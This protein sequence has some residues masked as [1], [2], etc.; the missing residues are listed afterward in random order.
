ME[1]LKSF[2][3][4]DAVFIRIRMGNLDHQHF[5]VGQKNGMGQKLVWVEILA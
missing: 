1:L 3:L 5:G 4:M 2:E